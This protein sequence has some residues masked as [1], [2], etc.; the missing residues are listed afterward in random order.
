MASHVNLRD[1]KYLQIVI[2]FNYLCRA[3]FLKYFLFKNVLK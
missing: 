2:A 3:L 1:L